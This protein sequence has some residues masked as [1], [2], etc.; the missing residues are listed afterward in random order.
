MKIR[1]FILNIG[2]SGATKVVLVAPVPTA[3]RKCIRV[4]RVKEVAK[5]GSI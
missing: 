2:K 4:S 1:K 3:L 5:P